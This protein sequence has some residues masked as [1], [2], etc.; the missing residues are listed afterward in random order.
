MNIYTH[1]RRY[2]I[3]IIGLA[4]LISILSLGYS[5]FLVEKLSEQERKRVEL[6]AEATRR[7]AQT[8]NMN[9]DLTFVSEVITRNDNIPVILTNENDSIISHKNLNERK[10]VN[11]EYLK[12]RLSQMKEKHDP[13]IIDILNG[14]IERR[15]YYDDSTLLSMLFWFPFVQIGIFGL[16]ILMAYM[17]FSASRRAEQNQVWVGMSK[18]TAHQLG[19]PISSLIAWVELMKAEQKCHEYADEMQADLSR[20][21]TIVERFSKVGARPVLKPTDIDQVLANSV[22]YMKRRASTQIEINYIKNESDSNIVPLNKALFSWVIENVIKNAI[23]AIE[24]KGTIKISV[25]HDKKHLNVDI[26]DTGKGIS[27]T[28]FKR[29]FQPGITTKQR[30]WGLGLSLS[31]R[32]INDYHKGNIFVKWSEPGKGTIIRI[33]LKTPVN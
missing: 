30:G 27:R 13:V 26:E 5:N 24:R 14:K 16:F 20:L 23:D 2:K 6:F 3:A 9:E 15:V 4:I 7:F 32:I 22:A 33:E 17:A 28:K 8:D 10:A 1:K 11:P 12:R 29:I 25:V 31:K 19:T 18:E 21:E